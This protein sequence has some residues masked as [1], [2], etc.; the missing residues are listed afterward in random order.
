MIRSL[1]VLT[2]HCARRGVPDCDVDDARAGRRHADDDVSRIY[3]REMGQPDAPNDTGNQYQLT[4]AQKAMTCAD[5]TTWAKKPIARHIDGRPMMPSYPPL[6]AGP[7]GYVCKGS[8]DNTAHAYRGHCLKQGT[9]TFA[10]GFTWSN[11]ATP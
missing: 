9:T 1:A 4:I 6:T 10:P 11:H 2:R 3:V 7:P 5:A 8:P